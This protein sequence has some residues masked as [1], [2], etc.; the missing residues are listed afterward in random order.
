MESNVRE[1]IK[2]NI[3]G[4]RRVA[5]L[6]DEYDA[7]AFVLI[8]TDKAV[9]PTSVMGATKQLAERY[10]H[11][12]SQQSSTRFVVVRFGNV[13]GSAGSVVPIFKDQIR[14]GGPI[15]ITDSRMTRYFMTIPEASQL[16]LQ[17]AAMGKGGEIFVLEMG[18]PV[19]IVDLAQDL[20]RLSGLPADAIEVAV[21]G[22]RPG[23]KLIEELYFDDETTLPTSHCKVRVV[24]HRPCAVSDVRQEISKLEAMLGRTEQSIRNTLQQMV[25]EYRPAPESTSS[26]ISHEIEQLPT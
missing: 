11:A 1:A 13:L 20:V 4:T 17:A 16:V 23:E 8:S 12:L 10:V 15:T 26:I 19:K 18:E 7:K 25:P 9:N 5:D 14:R 2:N 22:I 3:L 21:T 24:H 6:A